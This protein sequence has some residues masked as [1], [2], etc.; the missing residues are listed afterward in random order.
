MQ[1]RRE[2]QDQL[3]FQFHKNRKNLSVSASEDE[4]KS[5]AFSKEVLF[6]CH[7]PNLSLENAPDLVWIVLSIWWSLS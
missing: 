5:K 4:R 1:K 2:Q 6:P 3:L 7:Q